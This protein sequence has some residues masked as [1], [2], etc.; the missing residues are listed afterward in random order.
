MHG[1]HAH[2]KPFSTSNS[3]A[4]SKVI[5]T[6]MYGMYA[7]QQSIPNN[8]G[9]IPVPITLNPLHHSVVSFP[10]A[11]LSPKAIVHLPSQPVCDPSLDG[12][13]L[14]KGT[15]HDPNI[16]EANVEYEDS[17]VASRS[18]SPLSANDI[19]VVAKS[20]MEVEAEALESSR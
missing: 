17:L 14:D 2:P 9:P 1:M 15:S 20:G 3:S 11:T 4:T 16:M 12:E 19:L 8:P 7:Y 6:S 10:K 18:G 13:P 5:S